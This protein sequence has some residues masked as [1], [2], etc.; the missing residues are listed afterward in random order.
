MNP[1]LKVLGIKARAPPALGVVP[2]PSSLKTHDNFPEAYQRY[3]KRTAHLAKSL[4]RDLASSVEIPP[5][6]AAA[7]APQPHAKPRKKIPAI[8]PTGAST[9]G[10]QAPTSSCQRTSGPAPASR[11]RT[12]ESSGAPEASSTMPQQ[13]LKTK[14]VHCSPKQTAMLG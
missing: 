2:H 4:A 1:T 13:S 5:Q 7:A 10:P 8:E 14:I 9:S 12:D 11:L 3:L 6:T